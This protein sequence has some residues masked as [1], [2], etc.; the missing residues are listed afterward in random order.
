MTTHQVATFVE[1]RKWQY[2]STL[3]GLVSQNEESN[4]LPVL[5]SNISL[6]SRRCQSSAL[7]RP[8]LKVSPSLVS[9]SKSLTVLGQ[10]CGHTVSAPFCLSQP[11]LPLLVLRRSGAEPLE[12]EI[13][14]DSIRPRETPAFYC[15]RALALE[16]RRKRDR[17]GPAERVAHREKGALMHLP[18]SAVRSA[19]V[20][21]AGTTDK[22]TCTAKCET[23]SCRQITL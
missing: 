18:S 2:R 16:F 5:R 6:S 23:L 7:Q 14:A 19:G 21:P 17:Q 10:P 8:S 15:G 22:P 20:D 9:F 12:R 1:E 4:V 11:V 3:F 13:D